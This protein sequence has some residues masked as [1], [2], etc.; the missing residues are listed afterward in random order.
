MTLLS[1][2]IAYILQKQFCE[3]SSF[4]LFNVFNEPC[5]V[6]YQLYELLKQLAKLRERVNFH[7]QSHTGTIKKHAHSYDMFYS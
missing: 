7:M 2:I 6:S 4:V 3:R 1:L 5:T